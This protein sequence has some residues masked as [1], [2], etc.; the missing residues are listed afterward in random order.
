[1]ANRGQTAVPLM[2]ALRTLAIAA[3][4]MAAC[5]PGAMAQQGQGVPVTVA[6]VARQD[7][8][9]LA[10]GIGTVQA[11]QTVVV[12]ARVDGTLDKVLFTEGQEVK[13]GDLLAVIDP[14][15]YVAALDQALARKLANEAQ[16]TAARLDLD[17]YSQLVQSQNA[18][19]QRLDTAR[20]AAAQLEAAVKGDDA[21]I[22]AAQLNVSFTQLTSPIDG[23]VGLRQIDPG[24][25]I[26]AA[27]PAAAGIVTVSQIRPIAVLFTLTQDLMP[28]IQAAMRRDAL[29]VLMYNS[30]DKTK[31]AEGELLTIDSA[32]DPAT[33]TIRLKASAPNLDSALWPGQFVNVHLQLDIRRDVPTVP[34]VAI[35][36][37]VAGLY[38]FV[39]KP[40][41]TVGV[42]PVEVEQDDGKVA[43]VGHGLSGTERVVVAGQ[44]RLSNGTRVAATEQKPAS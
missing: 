25:I 24:N 15:P 12:R 26:R 9:V 8:P 13:R 44:S 27:D 28:K 7:V 22:A 11:W 18:S 34:S 14:R 29:P 20:A 10:R 23:R 17:R 19:R 38:V 21:A 40:D 16:F 43:V 41:G 39:V 1:M 3:A 31:L 2:L 37:G 5:V 4:V 42:Q 33:G 32:I 6:P 36:R 30:D 35:Q